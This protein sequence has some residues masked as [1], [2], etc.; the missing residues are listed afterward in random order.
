[1][2]YRDKTAAEASACMFIT[3]TNNYSR[4]ALDSCNA[5]YAR[6]GSLLLDFSPP[7]LE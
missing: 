7:E 5:I 4:N 1:M 3:R 2:L 6:R